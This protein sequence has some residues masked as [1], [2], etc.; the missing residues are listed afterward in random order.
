MLSFS[1]VVSS[2]TEGATCIVS[3]VIHGAA[4]SPVQLFSVVRITVG[5]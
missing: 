4:P 5:V 3:S 1:V 2:T